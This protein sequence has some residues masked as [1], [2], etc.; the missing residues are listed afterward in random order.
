M[1]CLESHVHCLTQ[2]RMFKDSTAGRLGI[3]QQ[4]AELPADCCSHQ[5]EQESLMQQANMLFLVALTPTL[6]CSF[7]S[8]V[9]LL[10]TISSGEPRIG[11]T[12]ESGYPC[13]A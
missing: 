13:T 6:T 1:R 8:W 12:S 11:I 2:L 3:L 10:M 9:K 7:L 5:Q 4:C